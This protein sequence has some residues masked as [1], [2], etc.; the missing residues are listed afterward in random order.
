M[1]LRR[2]PA[3]IKSKENAQRGLKFARAKVHTKT[4]KGDGPGREPGK[5][6]GKVAA[7][8]HHSKVEPARVVTRAPG[9]RNLAV[10][11]AKR[12]EQIWVKL[13]EANL[14]RDRLGERRRV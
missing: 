11:P 3:T 2:L 7:R 1:K 4:I 6:V 8:T 10:W 12:M 14:V 9:A 5:E 13:H